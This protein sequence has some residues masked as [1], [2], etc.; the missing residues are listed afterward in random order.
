MTDRT[1]LNFVM[2]EKIISKNTERKSWWEDFY[3][4]LANSIKECLQKVIGN[5]LLNYHVLT[6]VKVILSSHPLI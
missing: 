5:T 3:K 4:Y 1:F 2:R 6:E